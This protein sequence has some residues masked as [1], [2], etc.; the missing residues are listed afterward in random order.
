MKLIIQRDTV[1]KFSKIKDQENFEN[2]KRKM[3]PEIRAIS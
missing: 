1:I 2:N 3:I